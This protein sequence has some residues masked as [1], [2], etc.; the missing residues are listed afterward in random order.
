MAAFGAPFV[1][2]FRKAAIFFE[3]RRLRLDLPVQQVNAAV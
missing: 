1:Q 3:G 2:A